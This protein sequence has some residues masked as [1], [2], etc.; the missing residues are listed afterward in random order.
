MVGKILVISC[1]S[2]YTSIFDTGDRTEQRR[3]SQTNLCV[4]LSS[5]PYS[6]LQLPHVENGDKHRILFTGLLWGSLWQCTESTCQCGGQ[7]TKEM[8]SKLQQLLIPVGLSLYKLNI[9]VI[10][11][12][13]FYFFC[14]HV[15][16]RPADKR[17]SLLE[18]CKG[19][20]SKWLLKPKNTAAYMPP[21]SLPVDPQTPPR[22]TA[23]VMHGSYDSIPD[24]FTTS[25]AAP[26]SR[27]RAIREISFCL[28]SRKMFGCYATSV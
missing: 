20:D 3:L 23:N 10:K 5:I 27:G 13:D 9:P 17:C 19:K 25:S 14:I 26:W 1:D 28:S 22:W 18:S 6:K 24:L 7:V 16:P 4:V 15:F 12:Q 2:N 21:E 11:E 8:L